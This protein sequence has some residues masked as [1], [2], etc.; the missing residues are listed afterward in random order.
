MPFQARSAVLHEIDA[1]LQAGVPAYVTGDRENLETY[2]DADVLPLLPRHLMAI[3]K[4]DRLAL[5]LY[6]LGGD[7]NMP[8]PFVNFLRAYCEELFVLVPF[9]A[10]SAGTLI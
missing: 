7:T 1:E 9:W 6:T 4:Q 5:V 2:V 3:G 10:H 8:W